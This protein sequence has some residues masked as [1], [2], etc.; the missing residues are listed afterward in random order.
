MVGRSIALGL[1]IVTLAACAA[2]LAARRPAPCTAGRWSTPQPLMVGPNGYV[3]VETPQMVETRGGLVFFGDNALILATRDTG[4]VRIAGWPRG[5]GMLA[6]VI[7]RPNGQFEPVSLPHHLRAFIAVRAI[8]DNHGNAHVFWGESPDTNEGQFQ[9]VRSIWH[10]IYDGDTWNGLEQVVEDTTLSWN[11]VATSVASVGA[12]VHLV[13]PWQS[14]DILH[15]YRRG[16]GPWT[17]RHAPGSSYT[18]L[19]VGPDNDLF[20]AYRSGDLR[21]RTFIAVTRSSDGGGT[22]SE[23]SIAYRSG[24][25]QASAFRLIPIGARLYLV[26]ENAAPPAP[27]APEEGLLLRLQWADSLH[28]AVSVDAGQTWRRLASLPTPGGAGGLVAAPGPDGAVHVAF[29]LGLG[30]AGRMSVASLHGDQWSSRTDLNPAPFWPALAGPLSGRL[31]LAWDDWRSAG[32]Y[33][34]P[35]TWFSGYGCTEPPATH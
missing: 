10:A 28:A 24:A 3:H 14:K 18:S 17:F 12:D 16:Q 1:L 20:L 8:S 5:P 34:A 9:H 2:R 26:W 29:N 30:E 22:W 35:M 11:V 19:A 4:F 21:D 23:P 25:G 15:A 13:I 27:A 32:P 7:R 6:G 31:Y 33:R